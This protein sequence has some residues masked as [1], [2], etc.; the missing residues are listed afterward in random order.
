MVHSYT[1]THGVKKKKN[2]FRQYP[3]SAGARALRVAGC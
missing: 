2:S 1:G 3:D